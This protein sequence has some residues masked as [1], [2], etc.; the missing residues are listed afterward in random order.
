[1][2]LKIDLEKAF[3]R[4]EWSFIKQSFTILD[5]PRNITD[6]IMSCV[7]TSSISILVNGRPT[8]Y[9][10]PTRGIRQG[11]PLSPYIFIICMESLSRLINYA[12]EEHQPVKIGRICTPI[13]HLLFADDIILLAKADAE[14]A[15][16]IIHIFNTLS[17]QSG[18]NINF[19]KSSIIFSANVNQE[20][21]NNLSS[22]LNISQKDKVGKYLGLPPSF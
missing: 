21:R 4:L 14:N 13:S 1:M 17:N 22:A 10:L 15:T 7:S 12:I 18:Q 3:D 6:L 16:T 5:F 20:E 19:N 2:L 8:N 11:D 9:F